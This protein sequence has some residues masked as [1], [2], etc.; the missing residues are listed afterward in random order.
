MPS[1]YHGN[2]DLIFKYLNDETNYGKRWIPYNKLFSQFICRRNFAWWTLQ[3]LESE[4]P[5][6]DNVNI[7]DQIIPFAKFAHRLGL[8][9]SAFTSLSLI[10]RCNL[11]L[12]S[13]FSCF[14]VP[15]VIDGFDNPIFRSCSYD[16]SLTGQ[17]IDL[18]KLML[19]NDISPG[20]SELTVNSD[21]PI[22]AIEIKPIYI[23]KTIVENNLNYANEYKVLHKLT[24]VYCNF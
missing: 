17:T 7:E 11:N 5:T 20:L 22:N 8:H 15:S 9:N 21:I 23:D 13:D 3:N 12:I 1:H 18:I 24:S 4:I 14:K 2:L 6:I 16:N 19:N 10:L